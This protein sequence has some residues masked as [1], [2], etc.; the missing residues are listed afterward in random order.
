M[1]KGH[2]NSARKLKPK[3]D[4][5]WT[6]LQLPGHVDLW[7][8]GGWWWRRWWL[9]QWWQGLHVAKY[10]QTY[11]RIFT[12]QQISHIS[13][14]ISENHVCILCIFPQFQLSIN[15]HFWNQNKNG[16]THHICLAYVMFFFPAKYGQTYGTAPP[17]FR[18]QV[19]SHW[20]NVE[21]PF[22]RAPGFPV[23]SSAI[24][25]TTLPSRRDRQRTRY[26]WRPHRWEMTGMPGLPWWLQCVPTQVHTMTVNEYLD[27]YSCIARCTWI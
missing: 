26:T 10:H 12:V 4:H 5:M 1:D 27:L 20:V 21:Y 23:P 14:D 9:C 19:H 15:G 16:G 18:I 3:W 7:W 8:Q 6:W 2:H 22:N 25:A 13:T 17:F 24:G 11:F